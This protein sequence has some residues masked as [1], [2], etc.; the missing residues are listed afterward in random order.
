MTVQLY[1]A[2]YSIHFPQTSTS[3][4]VR[5]EILGKLT[6]KQIREVASRGQDNIFALSLF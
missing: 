6:G 2:I 4:N 5:R 3:K 1:I